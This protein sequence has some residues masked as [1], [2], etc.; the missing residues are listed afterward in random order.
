M[1]VS[2]GGGFPGLKPLGYCQVSLPGQTG[3]VK[4]MG[5]GGRMGADCA[6][7]EQRSVK[8]RRVQGPSSTFVPLAR[9][10][11]LVVSAFSSST[12]NPETQ[13]AQIML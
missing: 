5:I 1:T 4:A 3:G 11:S 10:C 6:A 12:L 2:G 8:V 13:P 7:R 9:G